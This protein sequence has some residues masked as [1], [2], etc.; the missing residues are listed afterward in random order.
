MKLYENCLK[1]YLGRF[2]RVPLSRIT[3]DMVKDLIAEQIALGLSHSTVRNMIAPLRTILNQ[4]I[5]DKAGGITSNPAA[6]VGKFNM[7]RDSKKEINPLTRE[8]LAVFV[9]GVKEKMKHY[10]PLTL[11]L[12]GRV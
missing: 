9:N 1:N 2:D 10:C 3:R 4:A 8:E 11:A 6:R 12:N 5:E 7:R